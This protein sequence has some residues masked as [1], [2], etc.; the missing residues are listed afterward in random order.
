MTRQLDI[1]FP[2]QLSR[3]AATLL[4]ENGSD[5]DPCPDGRTVVGR[6]RRALAMLRDPT[7]TAQL[8]RRIPVAA[9]V[10]GFDRAIYGQLTGLR[11]QPVAS[12][13]C[14]PEDE[15]EP[16]VVALGPQ[17]VERAA[18]EHRT[19]ISVDESHEHRL[20]PVTWCRSYVVVPVVERGVVL[21][22]IHAGHRDPARESEALDR[23]VLWTFAEALGAGFAS[24]RAVDTLRDLVMRMTK[25]AGEFGSPAPVAGDRDVVSTASLT[26]RELEVLELMAAGQTNSQIA[27]RLVITEG[28]AKSHV[29]RIM[30]KLRAANR[31]EAVAA[32]IRCADRDLVVETV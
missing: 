13:G 24:A 21:G 22:L 25:V 6:V 2:A 15:P 31:A 16:T 23:E 29:K 19:P 4:R 14:P 5:G 1:G 10:L 32:W 11:W 8:A 12:C 26:A 27:R 30:R 28:T 3:S 7:S 18:L 9:A 20:L 17:F